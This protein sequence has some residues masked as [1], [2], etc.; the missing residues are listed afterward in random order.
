MTLSDDAF[1]DLLERGQQITDTAATQGWQHIVEEVEAKARDKYELIV[2]GKLTH[3]EYL[4][5][6]A[7][8]DGARFVMAMPT[9]KNLE[10]A[11]ARDALAELV[12]Q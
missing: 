7:W 12:E 3:E 1:R 4:R 8:L 11:A 6:T 2:A 10:I 5:E 9:R